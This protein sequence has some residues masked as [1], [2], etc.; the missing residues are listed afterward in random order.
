MSGLVTIFAHMDEFGPEFSFNSSADSNRLGLG[1]FRIARPPVPFPYDP[2][3]RNTFRYVHFGMVNSL[4]SHI[5]TALAT[6]S[7]AHV[8]C[9]RLWK[10]ASGDTVWQKD[11]NLPVKSVSPKFSEDGRTLIA[12]EQNVI[13]LADV[14]SGQTLRVVKLNFR[15]TAVA[16]DNKHRCIGLVH[17]KRESPMGQRFAN[18]EQRVDSNGYLHIISTVGISES[19]LWYIGSDRAIVL[20]GHVMLGD[21]KTVAAISWDASSCKALGYK[22]LGNASASIRGP[23]CH[24]FTTSGP[25]VL[26]RLA[27]HCNPTGVAARTF[28]LG[29]FE[30]QQIFSFMAVSSRGEIIGKMYKERDHMAYSVAGNQLQCL[31]DKRFLWIWDG[32]KLNA[33]VAG[34]L[35]L[36]QAPAL[37]SVLTFAR[38]GENGEHTTIVRRGEYL[39]EFFEQKDEGTEESN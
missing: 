32:S 28:D 5:V 24:I 13:E 2:I 35:A 1:L 33:R 17:E 34:R 15:P 6:S 21:T 29:E 25:G 39:F 10:A 14:L 23:I 8:A 26:I 4:N 20:V 19:Q 18:L 12:C 27:D 7:S 38:H 3:A 31:S 36:Q 16:L 9:V 37:E 30:L 22:I 11:I